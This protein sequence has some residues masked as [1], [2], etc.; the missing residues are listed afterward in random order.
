M[1]I[2]G[3][4]FFEFENADTATYANQQSGII[5]G[6]DEHTDVVPVS[7]AS[8]NSA[9]FAIPQVLGY[10]VVLVWPSTG[11]PVGTLKLQACDDIAKIDRDQPDSALQNWF[12]VTSA[13]VT[14]TGAAGSQMFL[15]PE[16][17]YGW[18]RVVWTRT[19]GSLTLTAKIQFKGIG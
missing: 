6:P 4:R 13:S 9:G 15:D 18:V 19:S 17:Y 12:D 11:T 7:A 8:F 14:L 16:A 10:S 3:K 5:I 2:T 1:R